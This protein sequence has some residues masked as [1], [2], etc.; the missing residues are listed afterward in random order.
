M[1][2]S[3]KKPGVWVVTEGGGAPGVV[4]TRA[5]YK[6]TGCP[7]EHALLPRLAVQRAW[8]RARWDQGELL[9]PWETRYLVSSFCGGHEAAEGKGCALSVC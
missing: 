9:R 3:E 6:Y 8:F 5:P 2:R 1:G 7:P 4:W